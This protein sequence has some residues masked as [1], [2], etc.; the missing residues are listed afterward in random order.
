M[1]KSFDDSLLFVR[2]FFEKYPASKVQVLASDDRAYFLA[3][4]QQELAPFISVLAL[5]T[6][7][8]VQ[9]KKVSILSNTIE[10]CWLKDGVG[11]PV[12]H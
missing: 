2:E 12:G 4:S 11:F 6:S 8:G 1:F 7:F 5:D 10:I 3:I 9:F